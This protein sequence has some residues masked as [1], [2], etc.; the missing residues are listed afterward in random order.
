[1]K[2]EMTHSVKKKM[3]LAFSYLF[4]V[5]WLSSSSSSIV[6]VAAPMYISPF[7]NLL[8]SLSH[9]FSVCVLSVL[10]ISLFVRFSHKN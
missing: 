9:T 10:F 4:I 1:M 8:L 2:G 3:S 7:S 5:L 6:A